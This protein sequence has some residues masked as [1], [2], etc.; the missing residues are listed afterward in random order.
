MAHTKSSELT[1]INN[2]EIELCVAWL[3]LKVLVGV[4]PGVSID[5]NVIFW[6]G[7]NF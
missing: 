6:M 5:Y 2:S 3:E 4:F 1:V 7:S